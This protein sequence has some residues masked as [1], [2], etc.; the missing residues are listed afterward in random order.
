MPKTLQNSAAL[1]LLALSYHAAFF[2]FKSEDIHPSP[3]FFRMLQSCVV[4]GT[5][6]FAHIIRKNEDFSDSVG[7]AY[8]SGALSAILFTVSTIVATFNVDAVDIRSANSW[9]NVYFTATLIPK[10]FI[11]M[12]LLLESQANIKVLWDNYTVKKDD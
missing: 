8:V 12:L 7:F 10:L 4:T 6:S 9:D 1:A 2:S 11:N 5:F 3:F